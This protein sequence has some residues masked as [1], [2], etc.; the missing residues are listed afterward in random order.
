MPGFEEFRN[1]LQG[2]VPMPISR[3]ICY[4]GQLSD[5][6]LH[7]LAEV[8]ALNVAKGGFRLEGTYLWIPIDIE[9]LSVAYRYYE[10]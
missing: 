3:F 10:S 6:Q 5:D 2:V 1:T 4:Q 7:S 9:E 8:L